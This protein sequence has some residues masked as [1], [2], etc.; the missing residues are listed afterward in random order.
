MYCTTLFFKKR[1]YRCLSLLL[2]ISLLFQVFPSI[3]FHFDWAQYKRQAQ[4]DGSGYSSLTQ[5]RE[6]WDEM[7]VSWLRRKW[8]RR[9]YH[10]RILV[11][12]LHFLKRR[13]MILLCRLGLMAALLIW[14]G[15]PQRQPLSWAVL[16]LPLADVL[17]SLLPLYWPT[18]LKVGAYPHLVRG[19][20]HLYRLALMALFSAGLSS[21]GS[22]GGLWMMGG[23]IKMADGA[24]A[25]GE[26]MADGTWRLEMKGHF[27]LTYKPC[28]FFEER[29]LL[30]LMRQLRTPESTAKRPFLR[31]E[32]L[33]EWFGTHQELISRW[34]RYVREGGLQK[35]NGQHD[36]WV[37]TPEMSQAILDIWVPNFWL[38]ASQ[39]RERLLAEGHIARV[40]EVSLKLSLI[41]I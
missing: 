20:H 3:R 24:W 18:V 31:Q 41:H 16:S 39:V 2:V 37:V 38:S 8:S 25:R 26:I 17:I 1:I 9:R 11:G 5:E 27:I 13:G 36:G 7:L 34:Q 23:C 21:P 29:V 32:W 10:R 4:P 6:V 28:G 14:S 22:V 33:A 19:A 12:R 40:E 30:V 35:L 15:W